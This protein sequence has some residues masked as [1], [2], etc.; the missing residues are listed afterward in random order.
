[1]LFL[2]KN[3]LY[4]SEASDA[5]N[6]LN[7]ANQFNIRASFATSKNRTNE[8]NTDDNNDTHN[9]NRNTSNDKFINWDQR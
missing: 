2:K 4:S 7:S 1:M 3:N 8:N 6:G 5:I 9:H